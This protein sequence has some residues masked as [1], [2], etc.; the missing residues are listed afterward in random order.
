MKKYCLTG[1]VISLLFFLSETVSAQTGPVSPSK[2]TPS[3]LKFCTPEVFNSLVSHLA[4]GA[5][6]EEVFRLTDDGIIEVTGSHIGYLATPKNYRNFTIRGEYSFK[7]KNTNGGLLARITKPAPTYLPRCVEIQV[8]SGKTGDL[9]GF[10]DLVIKGDIQRLEIGKNH[11]MVGNYCWVHA[12]RDTEKTN[13]SDWN[14]IEVTCFEDL[15]FVRVNGQLVN[16]SYEIEK[17]DTPVAI[18]SEGGPIRWRN[19]QLTE[20]L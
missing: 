13:V 20:E 4:D 16:W 14:K 10:H 8:M 3:V 9:F 11:K 17:I 12:M 6:K 2:Q 5:K 19:L 18:Q 15:I 7:D 1:F